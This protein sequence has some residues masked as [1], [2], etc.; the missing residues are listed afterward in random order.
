MEHR[1]SRCPWRRVHLLAGAATAAL[2]SV[3]YPLPANTQEEAI[4]PEIRRELESRD[5]LIEEQQRIIRDLSRRLSIVEDRLPAAPGAATAQSPQPA[6]ASAPSGEAAPAQ[7]AAPPAR[8]PGPA[9]FEVSPEDAER[10]LERTLTAEGALLLPPGQAEISPSL[11][12]TRQEIDSAGVI[13]LDGGTTVGENQIERD[14]FEAA[15]ELRL[16]LPFDSQAEF[17]LPY[18]IVRQEIDEEVGFLPRSSESDTGQGFQNIS[19][20]LAKTLLREDGWWPDLVG[21]VAWEPNTG[22]N[23]DEGVSLQAGGQSFTGSVSAVKRQD[24]IAFI[25]S[26]GYTFNTEEDDVEPGDEVFVSFGG[27]LGVSPETSLRIQVTQQ[28]IDD[29][30]IDGR[31]F[32]GSDQNSTTL[33]VGASTFLFRGGLLDVATSI[34]LT[35][36]APD[37]AVIVSLPIRFD[38]PTF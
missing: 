32:D 25:A 26:A 17:R 10:A 8:Q 1:A 37:Y 21:R 19:L 4:P 9:P 36:D 35:D 2:V 30:E 18:Q 11:S 16:G 38:T 6:A 3:G 33:T 28:F 24:P 27:V 15:V 13:I 5:R 22:R 14:E 34:G 31:T 29:V 7:A 12:Y 23:Q 20:G